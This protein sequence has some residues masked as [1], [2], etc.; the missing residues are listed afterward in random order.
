MKI[1]Y[2]MTGFKFG[3]W[4]VES[5]NVNFNN[6]R[7]ETRWNCICECGG[8][9]PIYRSSLVVGD[10][11]SCGCLSR[12]RKSKNPLW[13]GWGDIS[14][15]NFNLIR[16][17]ARKREIPF[18][19]DIKS[20]WELYITQ[21][22]K[23]ALSGIDLNFGSL[24]NSYE[25]TAS[26]D[27]IDSSIGYI[28]TN[29]HW[30]HKEVNIMKSRYTPEYFINLCRNITKYNKRMVCRMVSKGK[31]KSPKKEIQ[32][33][34]LI[35]IGL[36]T[37]LIGMK[38]GKLTVESKNSNFNNHRH[39]SRWDC[40]CECGKKIQIYESLLSDVTKH[41]SCSSRLLGNKNPQWR[42][43][44]EISLTHFNTIKKSAR[45]RGVEF[46]IDIQYIWNLF[47]K[48]NRKCNLS[49]RNLKFETHRRL[50][51][52]SAS[53]DRID[54]SKGY[55]KGNLQWLH[56]EI[57]IMKRHHSDKH[58]IEM[59]DIITHHNRNKK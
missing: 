46:D 8:T 21:D 19:L 50:Y 33:T 58:F 45:E 52:G 13:R 3:K 18:E 48:Q 53:L 9:K 7:K 4:T 31:Y 28:P 16:R 10:S 37:N 27:R 5:R 57:N 32:T 49:G 30:V 25:G 15:R 44:K 24:S 43:Y 59:C 1:P 51:D 55:V 14:L 12:R 29:V 40:I 38:C 36:S 6:K 26:L 17:S 42:G 34:T 41:C 20:I 39:E 11:K 22:R 23:C 35:D 2:D 56:K 47:L 54:S